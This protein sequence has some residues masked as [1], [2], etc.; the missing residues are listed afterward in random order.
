[1]P[2][3]EQFNRLTTTLSAMPLLHLAHSRVLSGNSTEH[4]SGAA[5]LEGLGELVVES[6]MPL[7][8][9]QASALGRLFDERIAR[10]DHGRPETLRA[11]RLTLF[12]FRLETAAVPALTI[13]GSSWTIRVRGHG[14]ARLVL[15]LVRG[16]NARFCL[17][18]SFWKQHAAELAHA[19][20][21]LPSFE[22]WVSAFS[23][24]ETTDPET[25][26]PETTDPES[27]AIAPTEV[28]PNELEAAK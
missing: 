5:A 1:V 27:T 15:E 13:H 16:V 20:R 21:V 17:D 28:G 14:A 2:T 8:E 24:P 6:E 25:T 9:V 18:P 12:L 4:D 19:V 11:Q 26:D 23:T 3:L 10:A 22:E 7:P